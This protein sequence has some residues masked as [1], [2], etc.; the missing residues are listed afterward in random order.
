MPAKLWSYFFATTIAKLREEMCPKGMEIRRQQAA[1]RKE[2]YERRK[3][4]RKEQESIWENSFRDAMYERM[5]L[6]LLAIKS[7]PSESFQY[8][9]LPE[10]A[11][12]EQIKQRYR[13]MSLKAHP[14][15][16]GSQEE[17]IKL[18]EHKNKCLK[19]ACKD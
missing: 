16:G 3:A 14:D 11:T 1:A 19:W 18:T 15:R 5:A 4:W 10:D 7:I 8:L 13:E 6:L 2:M 9:G 12:E 17:F